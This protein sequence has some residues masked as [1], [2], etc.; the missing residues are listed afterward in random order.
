MC[1]FELHFFS[2]GLSL[3]LKHSSCLYAGAK[4]SNPAATNLVWAARPPFAHKDGLRVLLNISGEAP[5]SLCF[6]GWSSSA[7]NPPSEAGAHHLVFFTSP[8]LLFLC[9]FTLKGTLR[10]VLFSCSD[11]QKGRR[12]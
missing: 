3:F 1:C 5:D 6:E 7:S 10:W 9:S 2:L 12:L 8:P 4:T 11:R